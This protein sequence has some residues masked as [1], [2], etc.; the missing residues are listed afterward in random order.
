MSSA[1]Y[2]YLGFT[3]DQ[4]TTSMVPY[5]HVSCHSMHGSS[6]F[7]LIPDLV[8]AKIILS[9]DFRSTKGKFGTIISH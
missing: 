6:R 4:I 1:L 3:T 7:P 5:Q 2:Q 9:H 8:T